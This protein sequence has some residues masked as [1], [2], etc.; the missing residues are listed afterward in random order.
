[1]RDSIKEKSLAAL[2]LSPFIA[3]GIVSFITKEPAYLMLGGVGSYAVLA[4]Y[5][6]YEVLKQDKLE[7]ASSSRR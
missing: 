1:M 5:A 6:F 7:A 3:G 4:G 2:L